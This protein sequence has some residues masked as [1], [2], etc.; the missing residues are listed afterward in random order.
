MLLKLRLDTDTADRLCAMA[1]RDLRPV[2]LEAVA[3]LRRGLGLPV[4][5][6]PLTAEPGV[7]VGEAVEV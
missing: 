2:D 7:V 4:P 6:P 5:Y 1:L 3:L